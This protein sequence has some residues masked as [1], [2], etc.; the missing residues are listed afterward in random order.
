MVSILE[1]RK[2]GKGEFMLYRLKVINLERSH[3]FKHIKDPTLLLL[4]DLLRGVIA[5]PVIPK[6][7]SSSSD[8][9]GVAKTSSASCTR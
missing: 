3:A 9:T 5:A 6:T 7:R 1:Q 8:I 2:G 4:S